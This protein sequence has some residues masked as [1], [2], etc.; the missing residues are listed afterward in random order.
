MNSWDIPGN[1]EWGWVSASQRPQG[2]VGPKTKPV[3]SVFHIH[4]HLHLP[5]PWHTEQ[6]HTQRPPGESSPRLFLN[7]SPELHS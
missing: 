1:Q 5:L 3:A 4:A 2:L 7:E 6:L